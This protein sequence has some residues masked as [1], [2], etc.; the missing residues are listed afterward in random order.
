MIHNIPQPDFE[1]FWEDKLSKD[2][3]VQIEKGIS[4]MLL[5]QASFYNRAWPAGSLRILTRT[6][7][8]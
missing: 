1:K 5:T 3:N 2:P 7:I 8:Q 4:F 6:E